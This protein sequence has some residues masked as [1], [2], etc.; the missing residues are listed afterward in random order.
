M[1]VTQ[2]F[3]LASDALVIEMRV[4]VPVARIAAALAGR[5]ILVVDDEPDVR[6]FLTAGSRATA[7][8]CSRP[9]GGADG[10]REKPVNEETVLTHIRKILG[11]TGEHKAH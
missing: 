7:P 1:K 4:A 5:R 9:L 3:N 10:T 11:V 6:T 2:L 8:R